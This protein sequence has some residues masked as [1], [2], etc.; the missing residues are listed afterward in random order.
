MNNLVT[1][2]VKNEIL[3]LIKMGLM[4]SVNKQKVDI[5]PSFIIRKP[6]S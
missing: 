1:N 2:T 4:M 6:V 3:F 5:K